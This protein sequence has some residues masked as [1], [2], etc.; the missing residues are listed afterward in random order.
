MLLVKLSSV[1]GIFRESDFQQLKSIKQGSRV[2]EKLW[3]RMQPKP[4]CD[5]LHRDGNLYLGCER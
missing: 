4:H 2:R 5:A 1:F 3:G